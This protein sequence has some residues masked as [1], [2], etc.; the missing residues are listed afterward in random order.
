ML[1]NPLLIYINQ[2]LRGVQGRLLAR[3]C[4]GEI[5][6]P[7]QSFSCAWGNGSLALALLPLGGSLS[8]G[9]GSCCESLSKLGERKK[10]VSVP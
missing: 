10:N 5:S 4:V 1:Q 7:E 8:L 9:A 6:S 3:V 2:D